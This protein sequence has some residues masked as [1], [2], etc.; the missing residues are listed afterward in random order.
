M[1]K[2]LIWV[3]AVAAGLATVAGAYLLFATNVANQDVVQSILNNP[4]GP[5]ARRVMLLTFPDRTVIP[6]N[7]LQ[8]GKRIYV[9]ADGRWWRTFRDGNV[10]VQVLVRGESLPG[11]ATAI[12]D[13][14]ALTQNVFSRLRPDTPEWLPDSLNGVLVVIDILDP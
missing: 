11:L 12:L 7:Y 3:I 6:L 10:P 13:D 8:E 14:P 2:I 5:I 9:G 4:Q 1:R